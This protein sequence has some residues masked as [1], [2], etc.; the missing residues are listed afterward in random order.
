MGLKGTIGKLDE[1]NDRL[2]QGKASKIKPDHVQKVASK[3]E[4]KAAQLRNEIEEAAKPD[5]KQRLS[6]KLAFVREQ[7]DRA[8][9]LQERISED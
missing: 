5:K 1:Y 8:R 2:D 6:Q 9:W 3:L 7:L 4:A